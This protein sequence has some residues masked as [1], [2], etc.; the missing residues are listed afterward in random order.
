MNVLCCSECHCKIHYKCSPLPSSQLYNF[1]KTKRKYT[2]ANC[3]PTDVSDIT[4]GS[5]DIKI[6]KLKLYQH[7]AE[8]RKPKIQ[9][10]KYNN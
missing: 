10:R 2:C 3:T 4:P 5:V 1:I 7:F 8:G 9:G 6:N